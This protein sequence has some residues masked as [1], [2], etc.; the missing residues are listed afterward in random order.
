MNETVIILMP[1]LD[2]DSGMLKRVE[3]V[4]NKVL[5]YIG[6]KNSSNKLGEM[7]DYPLIHYKGLLTDAEKREI[8]DIISGM[9][10]PLFL[11]GNLNN[12]I[13]EDA[14]TTIKL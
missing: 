2:N 7:P 12:I 13:D 1:N 9:A 6:T 5:S 8:L 14:L 3:E 11:E 10:S 4:Y